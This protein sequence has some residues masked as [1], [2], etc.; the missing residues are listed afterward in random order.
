[1]TEQYDI[2][3]QV[4]SGSLATI[5]SS[6]A[7]TYGYAQS[8]ADGAAP[9]GGKKKK[10]GNK[11]G[12]V[13]TGVLVFLIVA[14]IGICVGG[15]FFF[16]TIDDNLAG[17]K[18]EEEQL[19][20]K[21]KLVSTTSYDEPFY[22][23]LI[24][25]DKRASDESMGERS[26]TNILVRIDA[27]NKQITLISIPRDT[28]ITIY[29][30]GTCKFNAAYSVGG[31]AQVIEEAGKLCNVQISH[32]AEVDFAGLEDLVDAVGGV[33]VDVPFDIDDWEAGPVTISAGEQ[34]LD[35]VA[36]LTFAR[37]RKYPD[38]DF[39]RTMNQRTLVKALITRV[40]ELS[41]G[42]LPAVIQAASKYVATD[43]SVK[44]IYSLAKQFQDEG[45]I[46]MYSAMVPSTTDMID[47]VS[48]VICDTYGLANMMAIVDEGGDPNTAEVYGAAHSAYVEEGTVEAHNDAG[49]E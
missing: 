39:T 36:A 18:T 3:Q 38:G 27:P 28:M 5:S 34:H 20:I 44:D 24:G 43:M 45:E 10:K 4:Q 30:Y 25:S 41:P 33:D 13:L 22:M 40:F 21:E 2:D 1:M 14:L 17:G 48:Y 32:Y 37:S 47:E 7:A 9:N 29:G 8:N 31:A 46:T 35:G 15:Y 19:A 6:G 23:V 11:S 16:S 42:E 12:K 49:S 26:D